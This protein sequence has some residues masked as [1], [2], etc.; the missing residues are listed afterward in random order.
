M[1]LH[2]FGLMQKMSQMDIDS[3]DLTWS[4]RLLNLP[5][6]IAGSCVKKD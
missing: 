5:L 1:E 4:Q 2:I 3:K 6:M